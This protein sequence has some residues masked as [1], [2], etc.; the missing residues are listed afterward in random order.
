M[1]VAV[2]CSEYCKIVIQKYNL[3][4]KESVLDDVLYPLLLP[5]VPDN[6]INNLFNKI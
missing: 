2:F 3:N 6:E 4:I 5:N 1:E